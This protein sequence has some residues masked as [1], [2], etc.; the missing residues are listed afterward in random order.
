MQLR[1]RKARKNPTPVYSRDVL[2]NTPLHTAIYDILSED[3]IFSLIKQ[4]GETVA[5]QMS[6]TVNNRGQTPYSL[7][8]HPDIN[9]IYSAELKDT[10]LQLMISASVIE[11]ITNPI[12]TT[13]IVQDYA[14]SASEELLQNLIISAEIINSVRAILLASSSHPDQNQLSESKK[15]DIASRIITLRDNKP[16]PKY[17]NWDGNSEKMLD[18]NAHYYF[19]H[20]IGN[21]SEYTFIGMYLIQR[22]KL[23]MRVEVFSI[24]N[25]DHVFLVLNRA[26]LSDSKQ[27]TTWGSQAIVCD[28]WSGATYP[29]SDIPKKLHDFKPVGNYNILTNFNPSYH[30]LDRIS[31]PKKIAQTNNIFNKVSNFFGSFFAS[32]ATPEPNSDDLEKCL[33]SCNKPI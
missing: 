5:G 6:T 33:Q 27:F 1:K 17:N 2:G 28:P 20:K 18:E 13:T 8:S 10:L 11:P 22:S 19:E 30:K 24:T 15:N 32:N 26:P 16:H 14:Q 12:D 25:G 21:C 7:L 29:A 23:D 9:E 3:N 31:I 4:L